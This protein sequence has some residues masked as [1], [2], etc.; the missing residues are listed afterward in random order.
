[1]LLVASCR[2]QQ[3]YVLP[4]L[5]YLA[6]SQ[7]DQCPWRHVRWHHNL[8][9]NYSE[10]DATSHMDICS[11]PLSKIPPKPFLLSSRVLLTWTSLQTY[12]N[13]VDRHLTMNFAPPPEMVEK[14]LLPW[15]IC[16]EAK[17][18]SWQWGSMTFQSNQPV[19]LF[20]A[21]SHRPGVV[22][23]SQQLTANML[24]FEKIMSRYHKTC[25][26]W[27][28][29]R[30]LYQLMQIFYS[31]RRYRSLSSPSCIAGARRAW[32]LLTGKHCWQCE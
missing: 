6:K 23:Y 28:R 25:S 27:R 22:P 11:E 2:F 3:I 9:P 29:T 15:L 32:I 1:M 19:V 24:G 14:N 26:T 10:G 4:V 16:L 20:E 13:Y 18:S 30:K 7:F 8:V 5:L 17:S 31:P 12:P 21:G